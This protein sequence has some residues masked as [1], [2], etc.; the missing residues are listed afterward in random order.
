MDLNLDTLKAKKAFSAAPVA[1]DIEWKGNTFTTYIRSLSYQTAMGTINAMNGA[2]PIASRIAASICHRDGTPVFRIADITGEVVL[3]PDWAE[4][5]PMPESKGALDPD[6]A[7]ILL[8]KIGEV[9]RVGKPETSMPPTNSGANSS[10]TG[11]VA[12]Q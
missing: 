12:A 1:V 3:P 2:D 10:S 6:L 7:M 9:Q 8:A 5:D 11:S 4:G